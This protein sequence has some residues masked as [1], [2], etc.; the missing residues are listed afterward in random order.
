MDFINKDFKLIIAIL[1][2]LVQNI[3]NRTKGKICEEKIA[4]YLIE[5][6]FIVIAKN[7]YIRNKE[8]DLF[9]KYNKRY[10][11]VEVKSSKK[12][13][14]EYNELLTPKKIS[15]LNSCIN[16]ILSRFGIEYEEYGG[17]IYAYIY[18]NHLVKLHRFDV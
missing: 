7:I 12:Y 18:N 16:S 11:I 14:D 9:V 8:V 6:G 13:L 17:I 15:N 1:N 3:N 4:E 5:K 2:F 10:F